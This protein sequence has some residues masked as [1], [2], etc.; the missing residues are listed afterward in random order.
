MK[1][2]THN[3]ILFYRKFEKRQMHK[4]IKEIRSYLDVN[5]GKRE[6]TASGHKASDVKKMF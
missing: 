4:S 1:E 2:A 6:V 5:L 3:I